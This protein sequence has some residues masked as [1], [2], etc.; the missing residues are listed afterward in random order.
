MQ[1]SHPAALPEADLHVPSL[2]DAIVDFVRGASLEVTPHDEGSL[3]AIAADLDPGTTMYVAHTPKATPDEIVRVACRL[4]GMGFDACAHIA[5]RRVESEAALRKALRRLHEAGCGRI[6]LIAGDCPEP[7]GPYTGTLEILD[8]GLLGECGIGT[9]A[10]AGHPEGNPHMGTAEVWN[11]L[12]AKQAFGER[13]R[14]PVYV[15]SQFGFDAQ[16]ILSW[17]REMRQ[18]GIRLPVHV[19]FAGPAS[20]DK[21]IRYAMLCG[22]GTTL[23]AAIS[24]TGLVARLTKAVRNADQVLTALVR[25]LTESDRATLVKAHFFPFGGPQVTARWLRAVRAGRFE[26]SRDETRFAV[27]S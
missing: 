17:G 4:Q 11:A 26:L 27:R 18:R 6:L 10:V 5:A 24:R 3:D 8:S 25:G 16:A 19:G 13:T 14:T 21:L 23:R 1:D 7:A 15:V 9:L 2:R 20:A 12:A 22:V